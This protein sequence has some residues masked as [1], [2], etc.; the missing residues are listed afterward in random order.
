VR[1]NIIIKIGL[2]S[3]GLCIALTIGAPHSRVAAGLYSSDDDLIVG[4][5]AIVI[6]RV[7]SI[8]CRLDGED[9]RIFTYVTLSIDETLK[10]D[11]VATRIVLKEEGGEV[12]GQGSVV[13]GTPQ[14]S[15][16]ERVF[17]YLDTWPDGS[18]RVHQMSFGKLSVIGEPQSGQERVVRSE[19]GCGAIVRRSPHH[20]VSFDRLTDGEHLS[21]YS[22]IVRERLAA[23]LV[24]SQVF[25]SE[26]YREV[27]ILAEPLDYRRALVKGEVHPQF[28]LLYPVKSVR[29]FEPDSNQPIVFYVNPEGAPNPQ[30]VEDVGA[31]MT[32]WSNLPGSTLRV[33]NGGAGNVCSTQ[34]T[35]NA[36]SFNNCDGR[37]TPSADCSRIIALGGLRWTSDEIRYVNG[38][39]YVPASSGFISFNPYSACSF[40]NH[41][42]LREVATHELGHALGLGHSQH[43]EATMFGGAHFDGRCAG[44]TEDDVN[45]IA[46]VYP[47]NDL[48]PRPLAID[49]ASPI[50]DAVNLVNHIQALMSSGGVLPHTWSV[51]DFLGRL[52]TGLSLSTGGIIFGLP[53][54]TGTFNFTLQ[55][56]DSAGSSIQK[57]FSM[58]VRE[59]LQY[60]SQFLSQTIV[61]TVQGGQ[62]FG[63][64]LRWL[65]NGSQIWDGSIRAVA[66]NPANN[67]IWS[68]TIPPASNLTLKGQSLDI[69]LTALAPRVA[70]TYNFQWQL[71]QDGRGF[72]GQP[73]PNLSVIVT[74]G[75]PFID[76]PNPPQAVVGTSF[77]YQLTVAGGTSPYVWSVASGS[78]PSGLGLDSRTGLISGTPAAVG[79]ASC[80]ARVTD[81]ASRV[82]QKPVSIVV[83]A[84]S[85]LPLKLVVGTSFES[86]RGTL[87]NY[88]PEATGG[89]PPYT[90]TIT[91]GSLPEGI[92]LDKTSGAI[93]GIPTVSG[94]FSVMI[95]VRDQRDQTATGSIQLKVTEPELAPTITRVKYKVVKR[96]L[97]VIGERID[98][99]AT[100]LVNGTP[101]SAG[102]DAGALIAKPLPLSSGTYQIRVVNP[103]GASSQAYSLT[104]E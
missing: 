9:D 80:I 18:L 60:D 83:V 82:A 13:F 86:V 30:V 92:V 32:A 56:A 95:T 96:K 2:T 89:M 45:G 74:P 20:P 61:P 73:S 5:R 85:G 11:I 69:L 46:F 53:T 26:H 4:A 90:W 31:A 57:R 59:P 49:S 16:G 48:G 72:F 10:G 34:R 22:R 71:Y 14:F 70:G 7:L 63:V 25:Q 104:V 3:L 81:S 52:P 15:R 88:Q 17:L 91:A 87:F 64:L 44:I 78:L 8:A 79:S 94:D 29:W 98:P 42:D 103:S 23:N 38:Q 21:D 24:R 93:S 66:Q 65:N 33:V 84:A 99:E 19:P 43:P 67:T 6:G 36:I 1:R 100:L 75:P 28:K 55:V 39:A 62:Q 27:P 40:D 54:E 102:F 58:A 50:P 37:F 47:V 12:E 68:A 101:V 77:S 97:V 76:N 51:V 41:C 35:V